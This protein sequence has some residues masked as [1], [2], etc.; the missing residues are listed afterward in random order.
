MRNRTTEHIDMQMLSSKV[1]TELIRS[2]KFRFVD[3]EN[4]RTIA[5][6]YDYQGSGYVDPAQAKRPGHQTGDD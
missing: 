3:V 5:E 6:E 4:R 2:G 1:R